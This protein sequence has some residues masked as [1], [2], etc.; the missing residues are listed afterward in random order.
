VEKVKETRKEH[1]WVAAAHTHASPKC[2]IFHI[3]RNQK[4]I[5][6]SKEGRDG[7]LSA[8]SARQIKA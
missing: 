5:P 7:N 6:V 2:N 1:G 4:K 8:R 3:I